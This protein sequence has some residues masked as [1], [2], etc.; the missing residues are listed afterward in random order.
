M[1]NSKM[2]IN[3]IWAMAVLTTYLVE[4]VLVVMD[5]DFEIIQS[6]LVWWKN[7]NLYIVGLH[8]VKGTDPQILVKNCNIFFFFAEKASSGMWE[9][10]P[11]IL[12]GY[13]Y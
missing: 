3:T 13:E 12:G 4:T 1:V 7:F 2:L 9:I 5:V 8:Q 6:K 11:K 10:C